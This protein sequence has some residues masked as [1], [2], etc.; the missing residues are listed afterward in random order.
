[1]RCGGFCVTCVDIMFVTITL[2][3]ELQLKNIVAF[4]FLAHVGII[5][6]GG[7]F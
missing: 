5:C 4:I 7:H 1:M 6:V 3:F 2:E